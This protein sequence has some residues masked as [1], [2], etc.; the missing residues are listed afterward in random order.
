MTLGD[1]AL[2]PTAISDLAW[3][4]S[5]DLSEVTEDTTLEIKAQA[6]DRVGNTLGTLELGAISVDATP[7]AL[8][9][10]VSV[11]APEP[12]GDPHQTGF[13]W[14]ERVAVSEG[15]TL[16]LHVPLKRRTT[17]SRAA[18]RACLLTPRPP[19]SLGVP[20]VFVE[21]LEEA[22]MRRPS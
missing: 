7:P 18:L 2:S 20:L 8:T 21:V 16:S 19:P 15:D 14:P 13:S 1:D 4:L 9:G 3:E 10:A 5:V 6:T 12:V 17:A 22:L 11:T